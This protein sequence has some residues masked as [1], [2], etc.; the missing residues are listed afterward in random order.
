[1]WLELIRAENNEMG[2]FAWHGAEFRLS[3]WWETKPGTERD[4]DGVHKG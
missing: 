4:D 1:M 2:C 3:A